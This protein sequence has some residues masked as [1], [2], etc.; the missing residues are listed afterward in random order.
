MCHLESWLWDFEDSNFW[1]QISHAGVTRYN[2]IILA[3]LYLL[4]F[5]TGWKLLKWLGSNKLWISGDK[6][7]YI[8]F[9]TEDCN[10]SEF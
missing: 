6:N 1:F 4:D 2:I 3:L 10:W 7:I 5:E 8:S 9:G